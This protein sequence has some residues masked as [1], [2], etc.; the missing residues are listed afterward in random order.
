MQ[1]AIELFDKFGNFQ[2]PSAEAI[3][4]L[5]TDTQE[6]FAAVQ[7]AAT[8]CEAATAN[9]KAAERAVSDAIAERDELENELR[10]LRPE[11]DPT[12]AAKAWIK[13]QREEN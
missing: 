8:E 11:V 9:R 7:E 10:R 3:A 2:M 12:A 1:T 13:S 5:D 4:E 6:R